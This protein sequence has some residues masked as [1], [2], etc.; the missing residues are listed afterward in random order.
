MHLN[1]FLY[2]QFACLIMKI[3][4]ESKMPSIL[5]V[6]LLLCLSTQP[7]RVL[8]DLAPKHTDYESINTV[9]WDVES[10]VPQSQSYESLFQDGYLHDTR[11]KTQRLTRR[12]GDY[13]L[14]CLQGRSFRKVSPRY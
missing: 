12:I 2:S 8:A 10:A 11:N 9:V 4:L 7:S 14:V 13:N 5:A 3:L 6:V 1:A